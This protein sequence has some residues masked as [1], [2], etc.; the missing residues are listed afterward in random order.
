MVTGTVTAIRATLLALLFATLVL[1]S[2]TMSRQAAR[3]AG[4]ESAGE[5]NTCSWMHALGAAAFG[6]VLL[7]DGKALIRSLNEAA[8]EIFG[9]GQEEVTGQSL[10]RLIPLKSV[11][12]IQAWEVTRGA[13]EQG[14]CARVTGR[15]RAGHAIPLEVRM[16]RFARGASGGILL[17]VRPAEWVEIAAPLEESTGPIIEALGDTGSGSGSETER[18]PAEL[19][20]AGQ[21]AR[22]TGR[23]L[24]QHLTALFGYSELLLAET[25]QPAAHEYLLE[26]RRASGR[27]AGLAGQLQEYASSYHLRP[28]LVDVHEVVESC[29]RRMSPAA[30]NGLRITSRLDAAEPVIHMDRRWC[31]RSLAGFAGFAREVAP[32]AGRLEIRTSNPSRKPAEVLRIEIRRTGVE[33]EPEAAAYLLEPFQPPGR[34]SLLFAALHN[35]VTRSGGALEIARAPGEGFTIVMSLPLA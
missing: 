32:A 29:M 33:L 13:R 23:L 22:E 15:H 7:L 14:L 28:Q 8:E 2:W 20:I 31:E 16:A 25:E 27:I 3:Q 24:N 5:T 4:G 17:F 10:F 21:L 30:G 12:E 34:A 26:I 11:D 18:E 19:D 6:G 1:I 9:Y 35:A